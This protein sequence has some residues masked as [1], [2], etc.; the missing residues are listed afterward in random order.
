[1]L[2]RANHTSTNKFNYKVFLPLETNDEAMEDKYSNAA[3]I[4]ETKMLML[5]GSFENRTK[6]NH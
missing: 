5:R 1:M 2:E 6:N 3:D 4:T